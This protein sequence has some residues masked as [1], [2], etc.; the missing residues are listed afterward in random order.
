MINLDSITKEN[1]KEQNETWPYI[2]EYPYKNFVIGISGSGKTN[3]LLNLIKKQ[4]D[5]DKI[6]LYP[7]DLSKAKYKFLIK[8]CGNVGIKHLSD[9]NVFTECSNTVDDVYEN[10]DDYNPNRQRKILTVFDDMIADI[11][12]NKKI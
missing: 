11:M 10:I 9:S 12:S 6:Y 7:K 5:I 2:S 4:D 1:N 8:K 3:A